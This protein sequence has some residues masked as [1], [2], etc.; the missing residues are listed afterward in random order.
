MTPR[1][2]FHLPRGAVAA[3]LGLG[4]GQALAL[5][6]FALLVAMVIDAVAAPVIGAA[7]DAAWRTTLLQLG[8]LVVVVVLH[9]LLRGL[10]FSVSEKIG[11]EV[12]RRLRMQMY[13]HLQG[14][15]PRQ[16]QGRARGG[17]LLRF[18]GD[19]SML[20]TWISRGLLSGIVAMTVLMV[21]LCFLV[22]MNLS[23][24][25]ALLSVLAAGAALSVAT[26]RPVRRATA[27]M[28]RRRSL[29][30][31][32]VDERLHTLAVAQVSGRAP[33]EYSRLSRQNDSLNRA[34]HRVAVL[35]G[36]LRG[37]YA[38]TALLSVVVVLAVGL[39]EVRSGSA[40]VGLVIAAMVLS[41]MLTTPLRT[42]GLAH[43]Y[44][45]RSM[46]SR[47]KLRSFLASQGRDL[48][49]EGLDSLRVR[50]GRIEFRGVTV[51]GALDD[52]TLTAEPGQLVAITGPNG[53]GKST[54]LGLLARLDEPT[55]G[56]VV[57]DEQVLARTTPRSTFRHIGMVSP[58]LPLIRGSV[59]RNLM[60]SERG[61]DADELRRVLCA[62]GLDRLLPQLPDGLATWLVEG[63]R[64]L[65][66]GQRQRIALGRAMLGNPPILLLD[67]P[68]ISLD[69][70][71]REEF[72]RTVTHYRGTVL[73]ATHDPQEIALA[74]QVW[75]LDNGRVREVVN[76]DDVR[77]RMWSDGVEAAWPSL[78]TR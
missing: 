4:L 75:V 13:G 25:L 16:V 29:L 53:A 74:D 15:T 34:L 6:A 58:D 7:A 40:T 9:G 12:V 31:G 72:R 47:E 20:R 48:D 33:G 17:L 11:Y 68:T 77:D 26:A 76:G 52:V 62:T 8:L 67:E 27:T 24:G 44:W 10:E 66:V 73:L 23:M 57:V 18:V 70:E 41:R 14:M 22:V 36:R 69:V 5:N 37:I 71:S 63:G 60:Y 43:D 45:Q 35:R 21:T 42:I 65:P 3:V 1:L 56:E 61:A 49:P 38:A 59:R 32:N 28:R 19:L 64:N 51:P 46:V 55:A 39:T 2:E 50:R 78:V 54:L 30:T